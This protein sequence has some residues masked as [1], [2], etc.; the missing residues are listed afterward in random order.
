MSYDIR[1]EIDTGGPYPASVTVWESPTYNLRDIFCKAL[2][3]VS[4]V[5]AMQDRSNPN[6]KSLDGMLASEA[7]P[8]L[9]KAAA[10]M[11]AHKG[12]Y[13][14]LALPKDHGDL[15]WAIDTFVWL[16]NECTNHPKATVRV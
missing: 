14:P 9:F 13:E 5:E 11:V 8:I 10:H 4:D 12:L 6:V 7:A 15:K 3:E 1:L 2:S 16:A